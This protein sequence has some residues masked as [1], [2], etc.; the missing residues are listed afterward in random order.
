MFIL[1]LNFGIKKHH[2]INEYVKKSL[3]INIDFYI[4]I[5]KT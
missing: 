1:L 3:L 2:R 4:D 5:K